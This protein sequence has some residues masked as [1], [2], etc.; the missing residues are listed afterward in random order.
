MISR[1]GSEPGALRRPHTM[2]PPRRA[3]CFAALLLLVALLPAACGRMQGSAPKAEDGYS[4]TMASEPAQP[5]VG[6]GMLTF[7][8][9]DPAGVPV[10]GVELKVI[11]NMS[12]AGMTPVEGAVQSSAGGAYRVSMNWTMSGDW[13]VDLSFRAS[14]G[15]EVARRFPIR[16]Q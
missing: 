4:V 10:E 14:D 3:I 13:F 9:R 8:L 16:V 7:T 1:S 2:R 6:P 5:S 11:G 15:K 12:H